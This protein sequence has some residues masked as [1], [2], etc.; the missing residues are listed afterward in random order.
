LRRKIRNFLSKLV[1]DAL[2]KP[3]EGV[4]IL[5]LH[6]YCQLALKGSKWVNPE[7]VTDDVKRQVRHMPWLDLPRAQSFQPL[8]GE[9][10]LA[11]LEKRVLA[12]ICEHT[13]RCMQ[14]LNQAKGATFEAGVEG[15]LE[16]Y[17][18]LFN[19]GLFFECHEILEPPWMESEGNEKLFLHGLINVAVGLYHLERH[20][21]AGA[22]K[23]LRKGLS[24]LKPTS[25]TYLNIDW[26]AFTEQ[27]NH[28]LNRLEK[29]NFQTV[30]VFDW[31]SLQIPKFHKNENSL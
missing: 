31:T 21:L 14:V 22:V 16:R 15:L 19:A 1:I 3:N 28:C 29:L 8:A 6:C 9:L 2:E 24:R 30:E 12:E 13:T 7:R 25:P 4:R 11:N 5:W 10:D 26:Q 23:V 17:I 18:L 27:V 20:N